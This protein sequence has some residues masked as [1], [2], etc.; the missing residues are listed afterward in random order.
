VVLFVT[1]I[2]VKGFVQKVDEVEF[3]DQLALTDLFGRAGI[4]SRRGC[5]GADGR[6]EPFFIGIDFSVCLG[7]IE[8][9]FARSMAEPQ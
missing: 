3:V 7:S 6:N 5:M 9:S 2:D 4:F 8:N 1:K